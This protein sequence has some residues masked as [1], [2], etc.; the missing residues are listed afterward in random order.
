MKL[1]KDT[2]F[3]SLNQLSESL[4]TTICPKLLQMKLQR[5]KP[6]FFCINIQIMKY[7]NIVHQIYKYPN[8]FV[9]ENFNIRV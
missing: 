2:F 5:V 1:F 4:R 9:G 7:L 3:H 6:V 8:I